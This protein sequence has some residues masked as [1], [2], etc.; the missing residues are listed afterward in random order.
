MSAPTPIHHWEQIEGDTTPGPWEQRTFRMRLP[1]GGWLY[2]FEGCYGSDDTEV[3]MVH[4]PLPP[5]E[6]E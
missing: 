2:R 5:H 6:P 3:C 4:V 1:H